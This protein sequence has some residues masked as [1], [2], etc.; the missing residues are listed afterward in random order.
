M[1][2]AFLTEIHDCQIHSIFCLVRE[3]ISI[4]RNVSAAGSFCFPFELFTAVPDSN[5]KLKCIITILLIKKSKTYTSQTTIWSNFNLTFKI[6]E[7]ETFFLA[8]KNV[9]KKNP[10]ILYIILYTIYILTS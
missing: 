4:L 1:C 7:P 5:E 10:L 2:T 9:I 8:L 6:K 3:P